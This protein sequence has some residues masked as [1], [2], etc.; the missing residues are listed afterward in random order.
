MTTTAYTDLA[1]L[2]ATLLEDPLPPA[3]PVQAAHTAPAHRTDEPE[4]APLQLRELPAPPEIL[5]APTVLQG[6]ATDAYDDASGYNALPLTTSIHPGMRLLI[7]NLLSGQVADASNLCTVIGRV[8]YR[9]RGGQRARHQT[10]DP[11]TRRTPLGSTQYTIHLAVEEV[12]GDMAG[13][14][15]LSAYALELGIS[16]RLFNPELFADGQRVAISG[17]LRFV[18]DFD[19]RFAADDVSRGLEE[20]DVQI[21]VLTAQAAADDLPDGS[22]V[23]LTGTVRGLPKL[24][25]EQIGPRAYTEFATVDLEYRRQVRTPFQRSQAVF[26]EVTRIPLSVPLDGSLEHAEALLRNGNQ[27]RIEGRVA[28]YT[29]YRNLAR[30][31]TGQQRALLAQAHTRLDAPTPQDLA[32]RQAGLTRQFLNPTYVAVQVG[33]VALLSG[34]ERDIAEMRSLRAA[35][36]ASRRQARPA[37]RARPLRTPA[38]VA[39]ALDDVLV[40]LVAPHATDAPAAPDAPAQPDA[41]ARP[42]RR[43]RARPAPLTDALPDVTDT[44][45]VTLPDAPDTPRTTSADVTDAPAGAVNDA[46][47]LVPIATTPL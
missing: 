37:D 46:T 18:R 20:W 33:F 27:V 10:I 30:D 17:P 9:Q 25:R 23:Q 26:S 16:A 42:V 36:D 40:A 12:L 13:S 47:D 6:D 4:T 44:P 3:P 21:D 19:T 7:S 43:S 41:P 5:G 29:F 35:S 15:A 14:A 1:Q 32:R 2:R 34:D 38:A 28:P 31:T 22:L 8:E 24:R 45:T 39:A 11:R